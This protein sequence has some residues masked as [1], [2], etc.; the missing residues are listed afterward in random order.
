MRRVFRWVGRIFLG[1]TVLVLVAGV[2]GYFVL[3]TSLPKIDGTI[4]VQGLEK[5]VEI[6]R[7]S[8]GIPHIFAANDR[9]ASFALGYVHAQDRLLQM[10]LM[11]RFGAGRLAEIVGAPAL[12]VDRVART[13][14][15]YRLAEASFVHLQ[16]KTQAGLK[17]YAA[18]VNSYLATHNGLLPMSFYLLGFKPEPW[19]PADSLVWGRIMATRLAFNWRN[20]LLRAYLA[21]KIGADKIS[22]LWPAAPKDAP[23]T[24]AGGDS[25]RSQIFETFGAGAIFSALPGDIGSGASNAWVVS[26][27]HTKTGKPILAND[28]H[29]QIGA[30]ILWYLAHIETPSG[31]IIGATV[32]GVPTVIVGHN[33]Y[34]AWGFTTTYADTDDVFIE[35]IDPKSPS[36][37]LTPTGPKPFKTRTEIIKVK[38][39]K[40]VQL[41]VRETRHGPVL[42]GMLGKRARAAIPAG[43]VLALSTPWLRESDTTPDALYN[44]NRARNW[45]QFTAALRRWVAPPQNI[46]YA[47]VGG[48]IGLY[49][50]SLIPIR[51]QGDGYMP[52][53]GWTS[54]YDWSR[55]IPFSE[56]PFVKN[57]MSGR[58]VNANNRLVGPSYPH[59][60]SRE[61]GAH[62]RASRISK[63]L[64]N[65]A[66]HD[67][68]TMAKIQGDRLSVMAADLLPLLLAAPVKGERQKRAV[69]LLRGW[70]REMDRKRPEPLI[71][72]AWVREINRALYAD[73]LGKLFPLYFGVRP[74][75]VRHMLTKDTSWCDDVRTPSKETCNQRI[76][77]ALDRALTDLRKRYGAEPADLRWGKAHYADFRHP[78]LN[79][80]PVI[81]RIA[82]LS[83]PSNGGR[84][85]VNKASP[86]I[87]DAKAPFAQRS[88]PG[89][90]AIYD[91]AKLDRSRF[92]IATG[93]SGNPF[94][95]HYDDFVERWRDIR[96][97]KI[98]GT[99]AEL[100]R[101]ASGVLSLIPSDGKN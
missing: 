71:F 46:T 54:E 10:E 96:Y 64:A 41:V 92:I 34:I 76:A 93:Q 33:G 62:Y 32:P 52:V 40:D 72:M 77:T 17:A 91:L 53:P 9:D 36:K 74:K 78:V 57:P 2:A 95:R 97:V 58:I 84:F 50:P 98:T 55:F 5:P 11:R 80:V 100:R 39:G 68:D 69:Q 88:G 8:N 67:L 82:N 21:K 63:L 66:N 44:L 18:G 59:F 49:T 86:R 87:G 23:F 3:R 81:K 45:T 48:T 29:L 19:R 73:E 51:M 94:S 27:T 43:Q 35:R 47:D 14:G 25:N 37:Y 31:K 1:V 22:A 65:T 26:G 20:E 89:Y 79:Y 61:W 13:L 99:R 70:N 90:R 30:P 4:V 24:L 101:N 75:V 6:I 42:N 85:T 38:S 28:P 60:I 83:I 7:D 16:S 12:R 56:L 15:L